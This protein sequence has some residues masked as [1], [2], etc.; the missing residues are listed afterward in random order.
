MHEEIAEL[1][2][3]VFTVIHEVA[4]SRCFAVGGFE[5]VGKTKNLLGDQRGDAAHVGDGSAKSVGL[6][7]T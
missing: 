6:P 3:T 5:F 7:L 1:C 4:S 2:S